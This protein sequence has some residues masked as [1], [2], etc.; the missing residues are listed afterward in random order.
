MILT[1]DYAKCC[2]LFIKVPRNYDSALHPLEVPREYSRALNATKLERVFAKPFLGNLDGHK[3]G[4]HCLYKHPTQLNIL[5]SGACDGEI[6]IWNLMNRKCIQT[7]LAHDGFVRGI[8]MNQSADTFFSCGNDKI[9]K[10]WKYDLET[11]TRNLEPI[12]TIVGKTFYTGIDHHYK[13]PIYATSGERVEVWD[14]THLEPIKSYSWGVDSH[15]SV[16][17]NPIECSLLASCAAD[18][19]IILYDIRQTVPIRKVV[20]EMSSNSI[21]W[22][23]LEAMYFTVANEDHNLYTFDMRKFD[24]AIQVHKDHVGAVMSLDY[25]PTGKE[26]TSASY[27]K[28]IRI[29]QVNNGHSREVYHTK[30]MQHVMSVKWSLDNKYIISASDEMNIRLWK[31]QA[32][33]KL[34][35]LRPRE[36]EQLEY[37]DKLKDKFKYF[38]EIKRIKRHRHLPKTIYNSLK[39]KQIMKS[40]RQRKEANVRKHSKPGKIP[41]VSEKEKHVVEELE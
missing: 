7:Y 31:A 5:L 36:R 23:P 34:G 22:N 13:K 33:D 14:E 12:Q 6:K 17:F 30:R 4:V 26:F 37:N 40:S 39:E 18:R 16:K 15:Y 24:Q 11:E 27:D 41:F 25:A 38:P 20:L 2:F 28:T 21:C 10:H 32:A 19:S 29:F 9:V 8:C 35:L 1:F 3:D